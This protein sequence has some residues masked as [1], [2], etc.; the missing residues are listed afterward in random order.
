MKVA[1]LTFAAAIL[2]APLLAHP[3]SGIA[4]D[5]LG[6]VYFLDT[7]SGLWKIDAHG[8]VTRIAPQRFHWLALDARDRFGSAPL[9]SGSGWE[10]VRAGSSPTILLAS[11]FP[12]VIGRDGSLYYAPPSSANSVDFMRLPPGGTSTVVARLQISNLK[13]LAVATDGSLY[14]TEDDAIKRI[15]ADGKTFTVAAH[16]TVSGCASVPGTEPNNPTLR[17][18]AVDADGTIYVAASGCGSVLKLAPNGR[19]TKVLQIDPP[20]SPTAVALSG[21]TL[22]VLEYLHT[23]NEDRLAWVPRVRKVSPD[24]KQAIVAKITR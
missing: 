8:A 15:S 13:G 3:G 18:L 2:A 14:Y 11:D 19:I 16:V 9:P 17:G 1:V 21:R 22:Y 20:W 24:G 5:R 10:I 6:Q 7:G 4:V 12:M 23:A